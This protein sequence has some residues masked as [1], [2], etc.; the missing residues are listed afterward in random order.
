MIVTGRW[1]QTVRTRWTAVNASLPGGASE[2]TEAD[3]EGRWRV[4]AD[5]VSD[6]TGASPLPIPRVDSKSRTGWAVRTPFLSRGGLGAS[7]RIPQEL[8]PLST[9]ITSS[10]RDSWSP[11][12]TPVTLLSTVGKAALG[13]VPP[14]HV[15][16]AGCVSLLVPNI[17]PRPARVT[18]VAGE[19]GR[20]PGGPCQSPVQM[21]WMPPSV[22]GATSALNLTGPFG[23][24]FTKEL[25]ARER[26]DDGF[27]PS[28]YGNHVP[29]AG[30][31]SA[32]TARGRPGRVLRLRAIPSHFRGPRRRRGPP[33][34]QRG[35]LAP[36]RQLG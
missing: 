21:N 28:W 18:A 20:A 29:V 6:E 8:S 36:V 32:L 33:A 23:T 14:G 24:K 10:G 31:A 4:L 15:P 9:P 16:T 25:K 27:R 34:R 30:E 7:G 5:G 3:P 13:T 1:A 35:G 2:L 19:H 12:E 22:Q 11:A 17:I 26:H